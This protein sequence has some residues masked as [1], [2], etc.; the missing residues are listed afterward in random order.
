MARLLHDHD[1]TASKVG[2][3]RPQDGREP[4]DDRGCARIAQP[5]D[6]HAGVS[7]PRDGGNLAEIEVER[8]DDPALDPRLREDLAVGKPMKTLVAEVE[9]VVALLPQPARDRELDSHVR[10]ETHGS[11]RGMHLFLRQPGGVPK[12][13]LDVLALQIRILA[14]DLLE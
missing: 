14:Q 3:D 5:E 8:Q 11:L 10:E 12:G 7:C 6:D 9:G 2:C 1:R 4:R 13:L